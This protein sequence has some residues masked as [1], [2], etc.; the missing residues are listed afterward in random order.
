MP[1]E[2][3]ADAEWIDEAWDVLCREFP[4]E[5]IAVAGQAVVAHDPSFERV[6]RQ[7]VRQGRVVDERLRR[8]GASSNLERVIFAYPLPP[9]LQLPEE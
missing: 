1:I 7:L 4:L 8:A 2:P 9:M 3:R 6:V 5:W